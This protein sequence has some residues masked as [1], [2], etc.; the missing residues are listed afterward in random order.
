VPATGDETSLPTITVE[1]VRAW[2][3]THVLR[4]PSVIAIVGDADPDELAGLASAAFGELGGGELARLDAPSWPSREI[5]RV[6]RRDKAQTALAL[7]FPGPSRTDDA[8]FAAAMIAGVTSGLGGRFFD[9][10]RDKQSLGYTVHAFASERA[11]AGAFVSYIATSP[12]KEEVARRGLLAEFAKLRESP[13][14]AKELTQAQTYAIGTHAIRQQSGGAVLGDMV[15]AWMFG[16]LAELGEF[17]ARV[18]AVTAEQ[19]RAIA[20]DYFDESRRVEGIVRGVG[21]TV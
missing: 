20:R 16:R 9:E 14:T 19:M 6:E 2:H 17:D 12:E 4:G 7:M 8:R 13:V 5:Q 10:L 18:R 15:D 3:R 11:L 1:Q 21:K